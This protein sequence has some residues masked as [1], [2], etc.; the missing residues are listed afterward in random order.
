MDEPPNQCKLQLF[1]EGMDLW[2]NLDCRVVTAL[3]QFW[4]SITKHPD[5][6]HHEAFVRQAIQLQA[7]SNAVKKCVEH[8]PGAMLRQ[9]H[10]KLKNNNVKMTLE[11]MS[12][13][14]QCLCHSKYTETLRSCTCSSCSTVL[15]FDERYERYNWFS[16]LSFPLIQYCK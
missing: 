11:T 16:P 13:D 10:H 15:N 9:A 1:W 8:F 4:N 14:L 5:N 2:E 3:V 7:L 12:L 6:L